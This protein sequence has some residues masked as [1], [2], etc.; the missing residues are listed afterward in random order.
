VDHRRPTEIKAINGFVV[1]EAERL[2][3]NV[4]VNRTLTALVETMEAHY[5]LQK[6]EDRKQMSDR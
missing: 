5:K 3:I 1:R 4:P 6:T 2:G